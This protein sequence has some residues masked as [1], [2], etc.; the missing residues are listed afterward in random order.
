LAVVLGAARSLGDSAVRHNSRLK[1]PAYTLDYVSIHPVTTKIQVSFLTQLPERKETAQ[2]FHHEA[3]GDFKTVAEFIGCHR[4]KLRMDQKHCILHITNL[5]DRVKR[6]K[7]VQNKN[8]QKYAM[9]LTFCPE[10]KVLCLGQWE[11]NS[12]FSRTIT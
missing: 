3:N 5:I 8:I 7:L 1:C 6:R 11:M 9:Q 10:Y 4:R 2:G 12:P